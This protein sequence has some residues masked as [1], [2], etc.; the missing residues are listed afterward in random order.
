MSPRVER[1]LVT[2]PGS[3]YLT[4]SLFLGCWS[5]A[6]LPSNVA[7]AHQTHPPGGRASRNVP[8]LPNLLRRRTRFLHPHGAVH[9]TPKRF[10]LLMLHPVQWPHP[11]QP[12]AWSPSCSKWRKR[13]KWCRM[14]KTSRIGEQLK[15]GQWSV[16][17]SCSTLCAFHW[18]RRATLSHAMRPASM[19]TA[20]KDVKME[21]IVTTAI[22]A[23]GKKQPLKTTGALA[24][25][26]GKSP[27]K[28]E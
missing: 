10:V 15:R 7:G 25:L 21:D 16:E 6:S 19:H 23:S 20:A 18:A 9:G 5:V 2:A 4:S 11:S 13:R 28:R 8:P 1:P 3:N 12:S 26:G 17:R 24:S 22:Y 14:Q 27:R